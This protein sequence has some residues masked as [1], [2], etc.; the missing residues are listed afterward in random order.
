MSKKKATPAKKEQPKIS[1]KGAFV[2][3]TFLRECRAIGIMEADALILF[4]AFQKQG[5]IIEAG[6]VGFS[7]Q[8]K[9]FIYK[10]T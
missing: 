6:G 1:I 4:L 3:A 10:Q 5:Q 8:V 9:S 7:G 2:L